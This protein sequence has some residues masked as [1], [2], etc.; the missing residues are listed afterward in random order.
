MR[1]FLRRHPLAHESTIAVT[2][3]RHASEPEVADDHYLLAGLGRLWA[4]GV[5][6]DWPAVHARRP[7]RRVS[8]PTYPFQRRVHMIHQ[9]TMIQARA[10]D[11]AFS[12][13]EERGALAAQASQIESELGLRTLDARP[14]AREGLEA[15]ALAR[16]AGY[17]ARHGGARPGERVPVAALQDRLG[18]L[19][20]FERMFEFL[21][22]TL[23]ARGLAEVEA[24][25]VTWR[26]LP[27]A[28]K[29]EA[30]FLRRH[31]EFAGLVRFL[32][33][34]V[35]HYHEAF[36]GE[37]ESIG[38]LYPD[39]SDA[40][41]RECM[42]ASAPT[43]SDEL[44]LRLARSVALSRVNRQSE[45]TRILE[46]GAGHGTLTWPLVDALVDAVAAGQQVEYVFSDIGRSF[47]AR[48]EARAVERGAPFVR[49]A[50]YDLNGETAGQGLRP[51]S[52][53]LILG[54]NAVH[55]ARDTA[56]TVARLHELLAP[57]GVLVL[58]EATRVEL[59]ETLIWG[60]APG[61]WDVMERGRSSLLHR[62]EDWAEFTRRAGF[63][64]TE[65]L[66]R[67]GRHDHVVVLAQRAATVQA[68]QAVEPRVD[69]SRPAAR[70]VVASPATE[71][72]IA[73]IFYR[74][75]GTREVAPDASF[76]ALGG[77]S[78]LAVQ[79]LAE[80]R[81]G[82][83]A[84]VRTSEFAQAP[85]I[86][87]LAR[88]VAQRMPEAGGAVLRNEGLVARAVTRDERSF[89]AQP[90]RAV[91]A[92]DEASLEV[93]APRPARSDE[94][95]GARVPRAVARDEES[96][97]A[98]VAATRV[99][100]A[101]SAR[102]PTTRVEE[103]MSARM[104]RA[105]VTR[106]EEL[107][108]ARVSRAVGTATRDEGSFVVGLPRVA[109]AATRDDA[110]LGALVP[111]VVPVA[112][113]EESPGARVRRVMRDE[114]VGSPR[115]AT[116]AMR[117]EASL[118]ARAPRA[119]REEEVGSTR[120]E[121]S[122]GARVPRDEAVGSTQKAAAATRLGA[123]LGARLPP[124]LVPLQP[125]G[126]LPPFFCVHG[127]GG[128]AAGYAPLAARLGETQPFYALQASL[129]DAPPASL[130]ALAGGYVAAI[131]QVQPEGP[132][133]IGG[134]SFGAIVAQEMA[135]QLEADGEQVTHLVLLD[136]PARQWTSPLGAMVGRWSLA[137]AVL[138]N[139]KTS[140]ARAG[141][142]WRVADVLRRSAN[143]V[144]ASAE[145]WN[146]SERHVRLLRAHQPGTVRAPIT[147]FRARE[148]LASG[149]L[150]FP[151]SGPVEVC[152][153]PGDH[154]TMLSEPSALQV[155]A[156][157]LAACLASQ[158]RD[159]EIAEGEERK[160]LALMQ[161]FMHLSCNAD[162][163][164]N[165]VDALFARDAD[166]ILFDS[167]DGTF[168]G[169]AS[170]REQYAREFEA[171]I[172]ATVGLYDAFVRV[173]PGGRS[174]FVTGLVD[175]DLKLRRSGRTIRF[176]RV[177]LTAV[178]EKAGADWR[179]VHVHY[180]LPVGVPLSMMD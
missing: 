67:A 105:V 92:R 8:L 34:A 28:A 76:F 37:V 52:F 80:V 171:M 179:V 118:G 155:L 162:A 170:I 12:L 99:E 30:G 61:F 31:P 36:R 26:E 69:A 126:E 140:A 177:R 46:V 172:D 3:I 90:L 143:V 15:V 110:P 166:T 48:A 146:M 97:G 54:F 63:A 75:L 16:V 21:L 116:A 70:P 174:A 114:E 180:S 154:F 158:P 138:R 73:K 38:V 2:T 41:Y 81:V 84:E 98:R 175:S 169:F 160:I 94:S 50:R 33:H 79:L 93:R 149:E 47:L 4:H 165:V 135:R 62:A 106:D 178:L 86:A 157:R 6:L 17:F 45:P 19:P 144:E 120:D 71:A 96:P 89:A 100:E 22:G 95:P 176:S 142:R 88:L 5:V 163:G 32:G 151:L 148:G 104:P 59:W 102:V 128:S 161:R 153:V 107:L 133:R 65:L 25:V 49:T 53:D 68:S 159:P 23:H 9:S 24:G 43:A 57:G 83:G 91:A 122:L 66:P 74:L 101:M 42:R 77:D 115:V 7:A 111:R 58:V 18:V 40:F 1:G 27:A 134:W 113:S 44:C 129:D 119:T 173:A 145:L 20:K 124:A 87:G 117:S 55:T 78:L 152:E 150:P 156:D 82:L 112:R 72:V 139:A 125:H 10:R 147:H 29:V 109:A 39:G 123:S 13:A 127:I 132:Y 14:G 167:Y 131:R 35:D 108:G 11:G 141:S 137:G 60:L 64:A 56:A 51:G 121:A 130:A 164:S 136:A 168:R 85:T 103:A